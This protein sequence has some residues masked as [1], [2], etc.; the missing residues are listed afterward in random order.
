M[1]SFTNA[2][3]EPEC[4]PLCGAMLDYTNLSM[5][6]ESSRNFWR[7]GQCQAKGAE[8]SKIAFDGHTVDFSDVPED[9]WQGY[10]EGVPKYGSMDK[11]QRLTNDVNEAVRLH[12]M[13]T[14]WKQMPESFFESIESDVIE[15]SA[16]NDE[17]FWSFGDI[18]YAFQRTIVNK[19]AA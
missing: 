10:I 11:R 17:G 7:C 16:Y 2:E 5:D 8:L 4:C 1:L 13:P 15:T 3:S 12:F 6:D 18:S 19:F 9:I 14:Y